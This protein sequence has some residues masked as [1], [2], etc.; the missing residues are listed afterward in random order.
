MP[1]FL[2]ERKMM[3]EYNEG[4]LETTSKSNLNAK[5]NLA[6]KQEEFN[7]WKQ[8]VYFIAQMCTEDCR[9]TTQKIVDCFCKGL[10]KTEAL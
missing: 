4:K 7:Q 6:R 5:I 3:L 10:L 2:L 8:F 1:G 9:L